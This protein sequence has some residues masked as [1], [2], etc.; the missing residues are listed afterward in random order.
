[1]KQVDELRAPSS[2]VLTAGGLHTDTRVPGLYASA[3]P[4]KSCTQHD[5]RSD[6]TADS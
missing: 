1:M 2:V 6:I 3:V 5:F 4:C